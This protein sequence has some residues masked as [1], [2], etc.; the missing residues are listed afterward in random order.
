MGVTVAD[1][2]HDGKLDL[3]ITNFDDDY[4]VLYRNDGRNS[5][6]DVSYAAK[7]APVSSLRRLGDQ[8][9]RLRQRRVG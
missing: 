6:A 9:L 5:F 8:V 4:N 2:D 3:F 7:V 1:Y